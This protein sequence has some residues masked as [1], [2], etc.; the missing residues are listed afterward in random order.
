MTLQRNNVQKRVRSLIENCKEKSRSR[1]D[2][3]ALA[4]HLGMSVLDNVVSPVAK[5]LA[6]VLT[7][8]GYP[9]SVSTPIGTVRLSVKNSMDDFID[10]TLD[11]QREPPGLIGQV[12]R[13]WGRR[14]LVDEYTVCE[15][16]SFA[17]LTEEAALDF[18]LDVLGPFLER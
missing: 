6:T 3:I 18:F 15:D 11:T 14:V 12:S 4:D 7:T 17:D 13:R 9:F 1:R 8:E 2:K 10:V 16:T 5:T